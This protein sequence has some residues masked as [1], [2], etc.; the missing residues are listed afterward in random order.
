MEGEHLSKVKLS[1][2][3]R[4]NVATFAV[5]ERQLRDQDNFTYDHNGNPLIFKKTKV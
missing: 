2:V 1:G 3:N 5:N 4:V